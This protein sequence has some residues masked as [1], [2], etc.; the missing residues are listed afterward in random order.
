M[1]AVNI[2]LGATETENR[3]KA[4]NE[5]RN[6]IIDKHD[7]FDNYDMHDAQ[8]F[9]Q[10]LLQNLAVSFF[11]SKS[12][13]QSGKPTKRKATLRVRYTMEKYV[14]PYFFVE[15]NIFS[16]NPYIVFSNSGMFHNPWPDR[17]RMGACGIL[18]RN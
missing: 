14:S 9:L 17:L 5:L 18:V 2:L 8:E 4:L 1:N 10:I 16:K 11:N 6:I 15:S 13:C 7:I 3:E 12:K